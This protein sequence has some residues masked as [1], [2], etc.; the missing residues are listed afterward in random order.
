[1]AA[2]LTV[3]GYSVNDSVVVFDRVRELLRG[4]HRTP[5]RRGQPPPDVAALANRACLQTVPRT[6]STG[7]GAVFILV[8]L[9]V[10]GG[11]SLVDFALALLIGIGVGTYSSVFLA[12]PL[13][14]EIGGRRRR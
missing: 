5:R 4:A 10:F 6:V 7:L 11:D 8:A 2:L 1:M 14:V 3:I 9:T 12:T 13:A